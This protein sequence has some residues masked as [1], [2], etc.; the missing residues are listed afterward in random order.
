MASAV[1][2]VFTGGFEEFVVTEAG[3]EYT[4]SLL[5]DRENQALQAEGKQPVFYYLPEQVRLARRGGT[6]DFLYQHTHFVGVFDESSVGVPAGETQGGVVTFT[7]TSRYPTSVLKQLEQ[8]VLS[9]FGG[10]SD[11]YWGL[12][13]SVA[14]AIRMAP[15]VSNTTIVS[16]I[17]PGPDGSVPGDGGGAPNPGS[18]GGPGGGAPPPVAPAPAGAP[19]STRAVMRGGRLW[20]PVPHGRGFRAGLALDPW[21][22]KLDGQGPGS[23]TGG[24]N[25]YTALIGPVPSEILWAAAHGGTNVVVVAQNLVLPMWSQLMRV[26]ITGDWTRIFQHFSAAANARYLWFAA[27]IQAEFNKMRTNGTIKVDVDIDGTAPGAQDMEKAINQRIDTIVQQFTAQAKAVIFDPPQPTVQPATAPSGG[28]LSSLFGGGGLALKARIDTTS[29][30]LN[31]EETRHFRYLQPHTISSSLQG[32]FNEIKKDPQAEQKYFRRLVLG[33]MANKVIRLVKTVVNWPDKARNWAGEPVAFLSAQIG[34]PGQNGQVQWKAQTFQKID[35]PDT[36]FRPVFVELRKNEVQNPPADWEPDRTFVKRKVHLLEP[37]GENEFPFMKVHVERNVLDLDPG[38]NGTLTNDNILEVRAD[39][40][41]T[42]EV[43]PVGLGSVLNSS[44]EVVEVEFRAKGMR[45]DG[46]DRLTRSSRFR[47]NFADQ[48]EP[49]FWRLFTGQPEFVPAYQYRVHVTVKGTLFAKGEAWSGPWVDG[50]GNGALMVDIPLPD[51]PGVVKRSL[52]TRE[53]FF[54]AMVRAA[55][56]ALTGIEA[57]APGGPLVGPPSSSTPGVPVT[58]GAGSPGAPYS[59]GDG[60]EFPPPQAVSNGGEARRGRGKAASRRSDRS[61]HGYDVDPDEPAA[62]PATIDRDPGRR[63]YSR[64]TNASEGGG[65]WSE[66]ATVAD[67]GEEAGAS[68]HA[69]GDAGRR[70]DDEGDWVELPAQIGQR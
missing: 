26:K 43:G 34:Y 50:S 36:T 51:A 48:E 67:S 42:L 18:G 59:G 22:W 32:F 64:Y 24:E 69:R 3:E 46:T 23:I 44:A 2:P 27:D 13:A 14:P 38:P 31:Y 16:N 58:A 8:Q 63:D 11:K 37:P 61:V 10:K 41:G 4:F 5:P 6:G 29:L 47:W 60:G 55:D 19:R 33:Q 25:A 49:R 62:A 54:E 45:A 35:P 28:F 30:T 39:E 65:D 68:D 17:A 53:I 7:I 12:R 15:I 21:A 20:Q 9:R 40:A 57:P 66:A 1:G 70:S 56:D 52:T